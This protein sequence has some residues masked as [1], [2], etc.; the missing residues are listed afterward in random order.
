MRLST[1]AMTILAALAATQADA[2]DHHGTDAIPD[3]YT[4][5]RAYAIATAKSLE[6]SKAPRDWAL[7]SQLLGTV[8]DDYKIP[9]ER[10]VLLRKAVEAA[11]SDHLV[12]WMWADADADVSESDCGTPSECANRSAA[13][14]RLEPDNAVAWLPVLGRAWDDHDAAAK[15]NAIARIA[16]AKRFDEHQGM[17]LTAWLDVYKRFP[18][19]LPAS[20][21]GAVDSPSEF[22]LNEASRTAPW[23]STVLF[24]SCNPSN[25]PKASPAHVAH[26]GQAGRLLMEQAPFLTGRWQG[27]LVLRIS[28]DAKPADLP[29]MRE[30][31]W[32][33]E[34]FFRKLQPKPDAAYE[35][36]IVANML[37]SGNDK[38]LVTGRLHRAGLPS[39]PPAAWQWMSNGKPLDMLH[40]P[41]QL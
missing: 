16:T 21:P 15:D 10:A 39:T 2:G 25:D 41:P 6:Q 8:V 37:S 1:F 35:S 33:F 17:T 31:A 27:F 36:A 7:A 34:Q 18:P 3:R 20:V 23:S 14:A 19:P 13:L 5:P 11:P 26:C 24:M 29:A 32:Q 12:R 30:L 4:V 40:A 38:T 9:H 28:G 22:A